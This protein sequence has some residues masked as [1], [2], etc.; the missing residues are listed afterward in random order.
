LSTID[1]FPFED[2]AEWL[3]EGAVVPFLGAGAS[4]AGIPSPAA[5]PSGGELAAEL[6]AKMPGY[7]GKPTDPLAKVAQIYERDHLD[8]W[9]LYKYIHD[10]F[11]KENLSLR[12][13]VPALLASIDAPLYMIT[14]NYDC[15][16]ELAFED[17]N[18]PLCVIT[19]DVY[20]TKHGGKKVVVK[21]PGRAPVE[22]SAMTFVPD[23]PSDPPGTSFLYKMH[24]SAHL[25]PDPEKRDNL[26]LTE[27]DYVDFLTRA[28][29]KGPFV[30]PPNLTAEYKAGRRFLFL[31]YSL[32]DWNLR[33]F[34]RLLDMRHALAGGSGIRHWAIQLEPEAVEKQLWK[35]RMVNLHEGNLVDF[36]DRLAAEL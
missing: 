19:Q 11:Y 36:C 2:V 4:A 35:H 9:G 17:A 12:A 14:T 20:D 10:R 30:P 21:R 3:K 25:P 31:G 16:V 6:I 28:G 8:R 29:T 24:G 34:M 7:L 1:D 18:R 27:D 26:I 32:Q 23:D 5:P 33:A 22:E 13:R 15:Q